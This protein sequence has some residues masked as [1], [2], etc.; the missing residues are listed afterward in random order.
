MRWLGSAFAFAVLV[1]LLPSRAAAVDGVIEI[2]QARALAGGVTPGDAPGFPVTIDAHA[3][4]SYR[5]TG[6]LEVDENTIAIE[7]IRTS[8]SDPVAPVTIDLGGFTIRG[9][10]VCDQGA[11]GVS[12]TPGGSGVGIDGS[13]TIS[14]PPGGVKGVTENITVLHGTVTGMGDVG[15]LIGN[16]SRA[17]DVTVQHNGSDGIR[18]GSATVLE[19]VVATLN[20]GTGIACGLY[21]NV[22]GGIALSNGGDGVDAGG[23]VIGSELSFNQ[24]YG[25]RCSNTG[26]AQNV[27]TGNTQ[28][29]A[30]SD[31]VEMGANVCA[32]DATCP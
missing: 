29:T 23:A 7:V 3:G 24:G 6:N 8:L 14:V 4:G 15:I 12:C 18:T 11:M 27:F 13:W 5:L 25:L 19:R 10:V 9:P 28:G 20:G 31:C 16:A 26:Y 17:R 32:G 22:H 1:A 2:N 30:T 21:C